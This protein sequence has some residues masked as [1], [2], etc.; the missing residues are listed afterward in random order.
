MAANVDI[1]E[2]AYDFGLLLKR[3][4]QKRGWTQAELAD[5]VGVHK[6][7]ISSYEN[8]LKF[9][10]VERLKKIAVVFHVSVDYL[11]GLDKVPTIKI[12]D[13]S[14]QEEKVLQEFISTFIDKMNK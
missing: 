3:L 14:S 12:H 9:P 10:S 2:D 13:M 11:L 5:L 7:M 6:D 8:N 4:R 1:D